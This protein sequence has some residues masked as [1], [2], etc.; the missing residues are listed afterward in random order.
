MSMVMEYE[1]RSESQGIQIYET[2]LIRELGRRLGSLHGYE[3][4]IANADGRPEL[5]KF[6]QSA[7]SLEQTSIDQLKRVINEH[8][9]GKGT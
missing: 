3:R 9:L 8:D 6:W 1:Q 2:D 7:K 4:D 5:L